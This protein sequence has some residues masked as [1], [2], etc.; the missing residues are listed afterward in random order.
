MAKA[1]MTT[2]LKNS[3]CLCLALAISP[4]FLFKSQADLTQTSYGSMTLWKVSVLTFLLG[5]A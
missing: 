1:S 4:L 2:K 3:H 5:L